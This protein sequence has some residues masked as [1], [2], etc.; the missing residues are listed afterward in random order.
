MRPADDELRIEPRVGGSAPE[1]AQRTV[2]PGAR[3]PRVRTSPNALRFRPRSFARFMGEPLTQRRTPP[4]SSALGE[5]EALRS[6][7]LS[8]SPSCR[9][10]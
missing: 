5:H 10:T 3:N 6:P 7:Q 2:A 1:H 9:N 4:E 8:P